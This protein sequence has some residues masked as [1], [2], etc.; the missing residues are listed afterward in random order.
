MNAP[1]GVTSTDF[2][3][4]GITP[5]NT[6]IHSRDYYKNIPQVQEAFSKNGQFDEVAYSQ[7]YDSALRTYNE[8]SNE[9]FIEDY[10]KSAARHKYD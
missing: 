1:V 9:K 7:F 5:E 3:A 10:V 2:Y 8:F 6:E 4:N